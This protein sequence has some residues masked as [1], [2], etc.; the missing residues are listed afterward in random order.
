[1]NGRDLSVDR[2]AVGT[3]VGVPLFVGLLAL[4]QGYPLPRRMPAVA[5]TVATGAA[6]GALGLVAWWGYDRERPAATATA[7]LAV[8]GATAWSLVAPG[9]TATRVG[10]AVV[11]AGRPVLARFAG[12]TPWVIV[13]V[14]VVALVEPVVSGRSRRARSEAG[15]GRDRSRR[16]ALRRSLGG[17][18][19]FAV[20]A[21][22]PA[23]LLGQGIV[24][25]PLLGLALG[26]GFVAAS[27]AGYLFVRHR[28]V[29][30]ILALGFVAA[31]ATVTVTAGGS[32]RG[33]PTAW[34]VWF[35]PGLVLGGFEVVG[36]R[37][38]GWVR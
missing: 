4:L 30:P 31:A 27:V 23:A 13:A 5:A 12:V 6:L 28:I 20:L 24:E 7:G 17:G 22:V 1:M 26:G 21:V 29:G 33:F 25:P 8:L 38:R 9:I 32:P 18:A 11:L 19:T 10:D 37:I 14:G 3:A 36:R 2:T 15:P 16:R 35:L 34:T